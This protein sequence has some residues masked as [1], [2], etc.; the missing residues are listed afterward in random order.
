MHACT[1]AA[2]RSPI[3]TSFLSGI[4]HLRWSC[5]TGVFE[6]QAGL[7]PGDCRIGGKPIQDEL[8]YVIGVSGCYM[9][10][11]IVRSTQDEKLGDLG[12][13]PKLLSEGSH[14]MP[15]PGTQPH[16]D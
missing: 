1:N 10:Q 14:E 3:G 13:H 9:D 12:H 11:E 2:S 8:T 5:S 7:C 15:C 6:N 4:A 16:T